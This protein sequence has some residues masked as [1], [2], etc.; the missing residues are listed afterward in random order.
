MALAADP[1]PAFAPN[2]TIA[3]Q[4]T[5]KVFNFNLRKPPVLLHAELTY[6]G[7]IRAEAV[8]IGAE[9][10]AAEMKYLTVDQNELVLGAHLLDRPL[11]LDAGEHL[12]IRANRNSVRLELHLK[13]R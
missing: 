3:E 7:N 1:K 10:I 13:W 12:D 2:L 9:K 11:G 4:G 8:R 5:G 6:V